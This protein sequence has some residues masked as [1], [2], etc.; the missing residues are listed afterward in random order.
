V[1]VGGASTVIGPAIGALVY[2][3]FTDVIGPEL[4]GRFENATP[5]ILG[6]LLVIQ[7]LVAPNGIVGQFKD[8]QAKMASRRS[9]RAPEVHNGATPVERDTP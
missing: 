9:G 8:I 7:M 2:G 5:V 3:V 4:P 1:V 6:V